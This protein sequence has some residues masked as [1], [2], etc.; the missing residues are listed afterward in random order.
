M[1]IEIEM[2]SINIKADKTKEKF[3]ELKFKSNALM[4][5]ICF[6]KP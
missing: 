5:H 2:A 4:I 6:Y 1:N 3:I